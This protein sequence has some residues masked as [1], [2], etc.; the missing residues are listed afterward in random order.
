MGLL[1]THRGN[2]INKNMGNN[3]NWEFA[4]FND[5]N[6]CKRRE[7]ME[8]KMEKGKKGREKNEQPNKPH[9]QT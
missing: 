1:N 5:N 6:I 2:E 8:R 7:E 3:N 4:T 9:K